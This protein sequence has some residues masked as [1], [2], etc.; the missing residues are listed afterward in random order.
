[1]TSKGD[2]FKYQQE[3]ENDGTHNQ[4]ASIIQKD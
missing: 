3:Q 4:N 2:K 1:M